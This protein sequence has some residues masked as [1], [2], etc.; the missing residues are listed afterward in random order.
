MSLKSKESGKGS[1]K[2]SYLRGNSRS[3][4]TETIRLMDLYV[5]GLNAEAK[6]ISLEDAGVY[7]GRNY[8]KIFLEVFP[9]HTGRFKT[10]GFAP[11][12]G[13]LLPRAGDMI[14]IKYNPSE[15]DNFVI[16]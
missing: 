11:V 2:P 8:Y 14:S 13:N 4:K 9:P 5:E 15:P 10:R 3:E 16:I 6:I 12:S 1:E 7:G